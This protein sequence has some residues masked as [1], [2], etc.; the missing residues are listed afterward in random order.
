MRCSEPRAKLRFTFCAFAILPLAAWHALQG[1]RL[2]IWGLVRW[3]RQHYEQR[4]YRIPIFQSVAALF[5]H[6][7]RLLVAYFARHRQF[8]S[9]IHWR[10][11]RVCRSGKATRSSHKLCYQYSGVLRHISWCGRKVSDT[12]NYLGGLSTNH[13][14]GRCSRHLAGAILSF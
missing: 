3:K 1:S 2:L 7:H 11:R 12:E 6:R 13:L 10:W 4:T 9:R 5:H 14:T 8:R